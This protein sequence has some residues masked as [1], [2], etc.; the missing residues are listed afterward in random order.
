M[1]SRAGRRLP[2][3]LVQLYAG[4][5][6]YGFSDALMVLGDL[7]LAPWSV[8]HQGVAELSGR[9]IGQCAIALGLVVLLLWIPLRQR[10]GFGTISNVVVVGL[11]L[12]ASLALLGAPDGAAARSAYLVAGVVLNAL[13]T[14]AYI[15][16]RLGPGPRDGLMTGIAARG[17]SIRVVRTGIE[18]VVLAVGWALGGTV[19]AGT[20]LYAGAIGPLVHLLLPRVEVPGAEPAGHPVNPAGSGPATSIDLP[21]DLPVLERDCVRVVV[22]DVAGNVLLFKT[23]EVSM[24]ELGHW[25]E[26]PGGGIDPGETYVDAAVRELREETGI[27][28]AA[29]EVGP[30]TWRRTASFRHR[31]SR[32]LQH[33]VVVLVRLTGVGPAVQED[34]RLDYEK[35]DYVDFRWWPVAEV[36]ASAERFY[37]GRLPELLPALLAGSPVDEPFELWS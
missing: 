13:A 25:W 36:R 28:V 33:E 19:G 24:P 7:G 8:L 21:Q 3:R 11:S 32:R 6:L 16:A 20:V 10:P 29:H 18:V 12:D 22:L 9:P 23:R 34:G 15:G 35:D 2:R 30:P 31:A 4:L 5:V 26:L 14:A 37:P 17:G 1:S 27:R